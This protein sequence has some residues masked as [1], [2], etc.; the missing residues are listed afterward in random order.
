MLHPFARRVGLFLREYRRD[1]DHLLRAHRRNFLILR[2]RFR[3][4]RSLF[5][6]QN[7][8]HADAQKRRQLRQPRNVGAAHAALPVG[9][10]LKAHAHR[11][12]QLHLRHSRRLAQLHNP[13]THHYGI[14]LHRAHFSIAP[15]VLHSDHTANRRAETASGS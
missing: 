10:G 7:L 13:G 3:H 11:F 9:N 8:V 15:F 5:A 12:G 6:A 1:F 2:N 14:K 4:A